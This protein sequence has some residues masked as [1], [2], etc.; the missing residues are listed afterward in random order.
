MAEF[1]F[2]IKGLTKIYHSG[3][4]D[5]HV[6]RSVNMVLD[7]IDVKSKWRELGH[8]FRVFVRIT[9]WRSE[10]ALRVPLSALFRE[11]NEWAA[12]KVDD[13]DARLAKVKIGQ[14]NIKHAEVVFGLEPGDRVILHPSDCIAD[15]A[16]IEECNGGTH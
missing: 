10:N 15:R 11:G 6:L 8:D 1:V 3:D 13:G 7:I 4:V 5:I 2:D 14:R 16:S 12:F 9:V